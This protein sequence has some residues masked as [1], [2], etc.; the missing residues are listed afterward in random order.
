MCPPI[1]RYISV[2]VQ[3]ISHKSLLLPQLFID[4]GCRY[5]MSSESMS[6]WSA[7][8][9]I[10]NPNPIIDHRLIR[11][12]FRDRPILVLFILGLTDSPT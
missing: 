12:S 1:H 2:N 9:L 3:F 11:W 6:I 5:L 8:H 10:A 7:L 4:F